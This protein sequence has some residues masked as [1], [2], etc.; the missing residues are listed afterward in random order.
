MPDDAEL[1]RE[2]LSRD[3]YNLSHSH[4]FLDRIEKS[5]NPAYTPDN[6]NVSIEHIMPQTI[7]SS[8]ELYARSD[9]SNQEKVDRDWARDLGAN[10]ESVHE[11]YCNTLGNLTLTGYNSKL[12][13]CR[14]TVKKN[15]TSKAADGLVYGYKASV[16]RI[17]QNLRN[18]RVW[19][20]T[21]IVNRL[22]EMIGYIKKIWPY[23]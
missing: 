13:N 6:R 1:R 17:S 10:W 21:Q 20:E 7:Q 14:F 5:L 22:D 9:Y 15:L 8:N 2:L 16:I 4:Y 18:E 11:K 19:K 3:F 12:S 23:I